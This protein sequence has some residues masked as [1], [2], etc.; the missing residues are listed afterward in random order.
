MGTVRGPYGPYSGNRK[1]HYQYCVSGEKALEAIN[2][3]LPLLFQ[4]GEQ[5]KEAIEKYE[6]YLRERS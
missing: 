6:E 2:K 5:A 3:M 4:K 1:E